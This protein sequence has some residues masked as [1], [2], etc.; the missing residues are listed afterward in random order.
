M[1]PACNASKNPL[2]I[3]GSPMNCEE[4]WKSKATLIY[5]HISIAQRVLVKKGYKSRLEPR[6]I[7]L[8]WLYV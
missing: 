6:A 4:L 5:K 2:L 8:R 3:L 1:L 7:D